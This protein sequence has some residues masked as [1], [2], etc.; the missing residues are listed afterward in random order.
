ME[1]TVHKYSSQFGCFKRE[2]V[3]AWKIS[4]FTASNIEGYFLPPE[5]KSA[6]L[7][8]GC[9]EETAKEAIQA[10]ELPRSN[11]LPLCDAECWVLSL[12]QQE[13]YNMF[14]LLWQLQ[15]L[16]RVDQNLKSYDIVLVCKIV[17]L[18]EFSFLRIIKK[19]NQL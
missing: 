9:W 17:S 18:S 6:L 13:S 11:H 4:F 1:F 10:W 12:T 19:H 7:L 2:L 16:K 3:I 14:S 5:Y 8:S 15:Q